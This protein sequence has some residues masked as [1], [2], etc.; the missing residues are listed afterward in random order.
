MRIDN[1]ITPFLSG[2]YIFFG[3]SFIPGIF[4]GIQ[5]S[6]WTITIISSL[7]V[8]YLFATN[9]GIEIDS[10]K[11]IFKAYNKHFGLLKSGKWS[12]LDSYIG[13]TLVPMKNVTRMYSRSN[14]TTTSEKQEFRIYL[15]NRAKKPEVEIKRCSS[16]DEGLQ[17]IDEFSI[18]LKLPV[19]SVKH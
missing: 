14:R 16:L 5:H 17:S 11:R 4:L 10:E 15:V 6:N 12:S 9:S 13:L 1:K 2:P 19:Y 18:W 7:A 8:W 3:V